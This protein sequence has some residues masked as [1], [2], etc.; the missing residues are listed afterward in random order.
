[1]VAQ[2]DSNLVDLHEKVQDM[3]EGQ[4]LSVN[5]VVTAMGRGTE[6]NLE[7]CVKTF[8]VGAWHE[9]LVKMGTSHTVSVIEGTGNPYCLGM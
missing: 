9:E 2:G 3:V 4:D 8:P 1:M 6:E 7:E 5:Q